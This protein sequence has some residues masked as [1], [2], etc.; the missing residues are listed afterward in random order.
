MGKLQLYSRAGGSGYRSSLCRMPNCRPDILKC[1]SKGRIHCSLEKEAE[2]DIKKEQGLWDCS[3]SKA[4]LLVLRKRRGTS[5]AS[6]PQ[7]WERDFFLKMRGKLLRSDIYGWPLVSI[8]TPYLHKHLLQKW[9]HTQMKMYTWVR[10][11]RGKWL[12][13]NSEGS[14]CRRSTRR[15][16]GTLRCKYQCNV[17]LIWR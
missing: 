5:V 9:T 8:H 3:V 4:W 7:I 13:K 2:R 11:K 12:S 17:C 10:K 6:K 15:G 14:S 16:Q 1:S